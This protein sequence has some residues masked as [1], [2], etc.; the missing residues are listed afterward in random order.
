MN[1]EEY[2]HKWG[3]EDWDLLDR[4]I[5]MSLEV[6][7]IKYPGL[8][9][10]YHTKP[11]NWGWTISQ[12]GMGSHVVTVVKLQFPTNT[13]FWLVPCKAQVWEVQ[14]V[15]SSIRWIND[16]PLDYW[17]QFSSTYPM[18]SDLSAGEHNPTFE[19]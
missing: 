19:Q 3:G 13:W 15:E 10:H 17:T 12:A 4:M 1:T 18:N 14:E 8:Y 9:H 16:Y 5:N 7:R 6:E 11:K 2:K